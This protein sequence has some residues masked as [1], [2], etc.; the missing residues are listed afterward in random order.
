MRHGGN[1]P[2]T[3]GAV[4]VFDT[5]TFSII[6]DAQLERERWQLVRDGQRRHIAA[7][8]IVGYV[9]EVNGFSGDDA[10]RAID[11]GR[12][13]VAYLLKSLDLSEEVK[14]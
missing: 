3:S 1:E 12:V 2:L 8:G 4:L 5:P 13:D 10:R 7:N 14:Q 6:N 11:E 9:A